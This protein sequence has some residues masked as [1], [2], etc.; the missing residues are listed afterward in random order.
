MYIYRELPPLKRLVAGSM[1]GVTAQSLTYTLDM[2]RARM[3][4]TPKDK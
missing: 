1:A 2:A 3:A 4:I